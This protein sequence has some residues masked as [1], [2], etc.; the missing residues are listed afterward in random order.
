MHNWKG[1][2]VPPGV[3]KLLKHYFP[4]EPLPLASLLHR[5]KQCLCGSLQGS[6]S[7]LTAAGGHRNIKISMCPIERPQIYS[8]LFLPQLWMRLRKL[9]I[10]ASP[11]VISLHTSTFLRFSMLVIDALLPFPTQWNQAA[12]PKGPWPQLS[13]TQHPGRSF[14]QQS[15]LRR[16]NRWRQR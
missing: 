4:E 13:G 15:H 9:G 14:R 3:Y 6:F 7:L 12:H 2:K 10:A 5:E 16:W 8:F 1:G 11:T